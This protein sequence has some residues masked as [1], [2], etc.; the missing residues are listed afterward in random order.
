MILLITNTLKG[1][2]NILRFFRESVAGENRYEALLIKSPMNSS[3]K[4][5]QVD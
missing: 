5:Q 2:S 3:A 1:S 4:A